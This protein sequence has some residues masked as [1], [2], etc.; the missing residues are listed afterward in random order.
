MP[1]RAKPATTRRDRRTEE[2]RAAFLQGR[3]ISS[4]PDL[5]ISMFRG[6]LTGRGRS[7][8][9]VVMLEKA[10]GVAVVTASAVVACGGVTGSDPAFWKPAD[11]LAG[12][13]AWL[14][15]TGGAAGSE[16]AGGS[17]LPGSGGVLG[18]GGVTAAGGAVGQGGTMMGPGGNFGT[19]GFVSTGGSV[20]TGGFVSTGG[21]QSGTGGNVQTST[22]A[23]RFDVTTTSYGGRFSPR[24]V[25]AIYIEDAAGGFV[26]TLTVWG[27][28][29]LHNLTDW[30][31]LSGG[32]TT[33]AIAGATRANAGPISGSW[34][35]TNVSHQPVSDAQY[36]A[37]CSFQED[38]AL[39]FFGP[40]PKKACVPFSK[41]TGPFTQPAP[42]QGNFKNMTLTM[43]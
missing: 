32:N 33:D 28:V 36:Q 13:Q 2:S 4:L 15:S 37:C 11:G 30:E 5:R 18:N 6:M 24:N 19:G 25:G 35:C 17:Q 29:E 26:K 1:P 23:F 14:T 10:V 43:Q 22:C 8:K 31:S 3:V 42:D 7:G 27:T 40:A 16:G 39:P 38:D 34:D 21:T 41:G 20:S 9:R 12:A